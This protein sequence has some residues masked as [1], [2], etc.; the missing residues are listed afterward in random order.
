VWGNGRRNDVPN[1]LS[2]PPLPQAFP[3]ISTGV[4]GE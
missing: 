4:F 1:P 3:C 2:L